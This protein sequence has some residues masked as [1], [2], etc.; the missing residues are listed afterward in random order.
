MTTNEFDLRLVASL[1]LRRKF[2]FF[3]NGVS[4][5]FLLNML[6]MECLVLDVGEAF[7]LFANKRGGF[8][9]GVSTGNSSLFRLLFSYFFF[10]LL[11]GNEW[12]FSPVNKGMFKNKFGV[13]F[14]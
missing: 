4:C 8:F 1:T 11:V 2:D 6:K 7:G 5:S 3:G 12:N 9:G 13:E 14:R 10:L